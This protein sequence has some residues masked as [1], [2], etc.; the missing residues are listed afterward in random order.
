MSR[1]FYAAYRKLGRRYPK[2]VFTVQFQLAHVV[3]LFGLGLLT[4]YQ[5]I[6]LA[7]FVWLAA[8]SAVVTVI[9]N[10]V[11]LRLAGRLLEPA[12]PW[13]N[14]DRSAASAT[15]AWRA[16]ADLP[17]EYLQR[18][19]LAPVYLSIPWCIY[20]ALVLSLP[21]WSVAILLAGAVVVVMYGVALRYFVLELA[22]R[23]VL[24]EISEDLPDGFW[25]GK[26]GVPLRWKLLIGVPIINIITGVVVAGLSSNGQEDLKD[27]GLSVL[28]AVIIAFTTSLELTVLL[29]RSILDPLGDLRD[30]TQRVARGDLSVRVPVVSNDESG[31][32]AQSF[33]AA[34]AGLEERQKLHEAFGSYVDPEVAEKV[35]TDGAVL[36]G[37]E[38]EVSVFFL[39]IREFTAFAERSSAREVVS[40]LNS[41]WDEIV[42]I[43]RDHGGHAN[44]FVGDGLLAVFGAPERQADHADRAVCAALDIIDRVAERRDDGLRIGIG[45]NSG[46]VVAGTVGGGGKLDFTVIGDAV[47]T[48]SRVEECTRSTGDD[49]LI[50]EAT[51]CLLERDYGE[52]DP[53][54]E[55]ELKGKTE[56]VQLYAPKERGIAIHRAAEAVPAGD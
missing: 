18:R 37:E 45:V 12:Q 52:W 13:L 42:P 21:W 11:S 29:T 20:A 4:I 46:P 56:R 31:E 8:A 26:G 7:Q 27:L 5:D 36:E 10:F 48:A 24:E 39:D 33:N 43:I 34:V 1:L 9:E 14:G 19:K 53:R 51:R 55:T 32:L 3:A 44:K 2:T 22:L 40:V 28:V 16:L 23:P 6:S 17:P 47:N 30:A 41:L 49:V 38:L 50:T 15:A 25:V 54:Q 35:L